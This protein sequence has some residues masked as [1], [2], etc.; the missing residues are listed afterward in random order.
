MALAAL[1]V[2]AL[3]ATPGCRALHHSAHHAHIRP[4]HGVQSSAAPG[5]AGTVHGRL[6]L[7]GGMSD[8]PPRGVSGLVTLTGVTT[9]RVDTGPRGWWTISAPAGR[10]RV[11]GSSPSFQVDSESD[12]QVGGP[13]GPCIGPTVTVQP[14]RTTLVEV[15]CIMK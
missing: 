12:P 2:A 3:V 8:T 15:S 13:P 6:V 1:T 11:A 10:Y 7:V 5:A 9:V 4:G 14:G